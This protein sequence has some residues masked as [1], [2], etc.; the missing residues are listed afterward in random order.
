MNSVFIFIREG[1]FSRLL[2]LSV[3]K[4][5]EV[6]FLA[7]LVKFLELH[8]FSAFKAFGGFAAHLTTLGL[9][10]RFFRFCAVLVFLS[11]QNPD[12]VDALL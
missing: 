1:R 10:P 2:K 6:D 11:E 7:F 12:E 3:E 5:L 8:V 9:F 4:R